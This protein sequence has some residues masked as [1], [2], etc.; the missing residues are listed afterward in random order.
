MLFCIFEETWKLLNNNIH[1]KEINILK[2]MLKESPKT[3]VA[4]LIPFAF[5]V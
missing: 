5:A 3:V 4:H 2:F 1:F